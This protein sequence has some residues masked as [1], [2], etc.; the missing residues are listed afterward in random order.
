MAENDDAR[1][2]ESGPHPSRDP[3]ARFAG[4]E[5]ILRDQLAIDRTV[6]A[7]ER[8]LLA[9]CRTSL[10]LVL[11]GAGAIKFLQSAPFVV[12][13]WVLVGLGLA[14]AYVGVSR[15]RRVARN[16]ASVATAVQGERR[17]ASRGEPP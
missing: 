7:N 1:S 3:Y 14:L 9:Y 6:L 15:F 10:A 16:L 17:D 4:S 11:T 13:G 12:G 5:L 8:T 2:G